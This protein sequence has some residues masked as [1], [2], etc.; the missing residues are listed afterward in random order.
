MLYLSRKVRVAYQDRGAW[1]EP[2]AGLMEAV[3]AE[4]RGWNELPHLAWEGGRLWVVFR[5]RTDTSITRP[6]NFS[7]NGRWHFYATCLR[8]DGWMP[9][10]FL[11]DSGAPSSS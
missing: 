1:R 9:A 3:P 2:Q 8:G 11:P 6:D 4:I 10:V 7:A 5:N